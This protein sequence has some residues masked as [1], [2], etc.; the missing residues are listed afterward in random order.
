MVDPKWNALTFTSHLLH[1][2]QHP[3][4]RWFYIAATYY[5]TIGVADVTNEFQDNIKA[6]SE[7]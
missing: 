1:S 2:Y 6:S 7:R 3:H 5:L 4:S